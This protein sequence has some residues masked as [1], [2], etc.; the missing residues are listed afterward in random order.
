MSENHV[1]TACCQYLELQRHFFWR[2]NNVG[3]Y[4]TKRKIHRKLPKWS[5]K[6]VSD[7]ICVHVGVPFFIE[8]KTSTGSL[9]AAQKQFKADVEAAGGIYIVATSHD[10]LKAAGL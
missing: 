2:Q 5:K 3:I 9:S 8:C 1:L 4:D 6:G 7:I 10:D